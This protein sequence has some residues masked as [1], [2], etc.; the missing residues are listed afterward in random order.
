MGKLTETHSE[1]PLYI[2][3]LG[4][5]APCQYCYQILKRM[6]KTRIFKYC[7]LFKDVFLLFMPLF[8]CGEYRCVYMFTCVQ[9]S[10]EARTGHQTLW[11]GGT[12]NWIL[13]IWKSCL[14][15]WPLRPSLLPWEY[16]CAAN[17]NG[18]WHSWSG[19]ALVVLISV[20]LTT[21][22]NKHQETYL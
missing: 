14:C 11:A 2:L 8:L 19:N 1:M 15:S 21:L 16:L 9:M 6:Q 17:E 7:C 22:F 20:I 18:M 5:G 12:G 3:N 13:V 10:T 4:R